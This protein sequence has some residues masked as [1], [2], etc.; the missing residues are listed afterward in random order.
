MGQTVGFDI[1]EKSLKMAV[2]NGKKFRSTAAAEIPDNLISGGDILSVDAM[3]EFVRETAKQNG[4]SKSDASV[5][6]PA[7]LLYTRT[8]SVPAMTEKQLS[9]NLPFEFKDYITR[10]KSEYYFDYSV[11]KITYDEKGDP[12][13]MNLFICTVLKETIEE[14]RSMFRQAGFRLKSA[15]PAECAFVNLLTDLSKSDGNEC[16]VDIGYNGS[17]IY[18]YRAGIHDIS[19]SFDIG[20]RDLDAVIAEGMG[21]ES[22]L[23]H[24]YLESNFENVLGRDFC[25]DFYNRFAVEIVK[26]VN[27]YNYNS[28]SEGIDRICLCGGGSKI[29]PLCRAIQSIT[30]LKI[31]PVEDIIGDTGITAPSSFLKAFGA[32]IN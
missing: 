24:S 4:I 25:I 26:A 20:I 18:V 10:D 32:A 23:A 12:E 17:R 13:E 16:F 7:E 8:V 11:N 5:I 15:I 14:Y 30:E 3:A 22:H 28:Q 6:L 1:G 2:Y 9:Y 27:F 21:V 29:E 19:R 31:S